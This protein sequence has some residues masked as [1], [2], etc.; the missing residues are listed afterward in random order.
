MVNISG[1]HS[2]KSITCFFMWKHGKRIMSLVILVATIL[3]IPFQA[4]PQRQKTTS[5]FLKGGEVVYGKIISQDSINGFLIEN[6]CGISL[7]KHSDIDSIWSSKDRTYSLQK[8]KGFFNLSSLALLFGEG[9]DGYVPVPS[10]TMVN[11]YQFNKHFF[12]GFGIGYEY[13]DF[14]VLPLFLDVK[15]KFHSYGFTPFL[16]IKVG[17][18]IP[19]QHYMEE[20]WGGE[21]N[22]T[23]GGVLFAPEMGVMM[24]VGQND[25]F[26]ISVG[27][28][29]QQ[30]S[31]DSPTYYWY[32]PESS[33]AKRRIF[34]N[35][36]RISLR[37]SFLFR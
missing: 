29:Y 23:Y 3:I 27:Y 21:Q 5:V 20:N 26:L 35:Y 37:V 13:Y 19:L 36:N 1:K 7:I 11:G 12:T 6:D 8:T 25:A 14:G 15:Y 33:H 2:E 31:Y 16:S 10:L 30:L 17:G 9:R 18:S 4:Y 34:T 24:P 22:N 32:L 28:H